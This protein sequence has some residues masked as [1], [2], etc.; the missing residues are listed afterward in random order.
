M[1]LKKM[2][3]VQN[4]D[5]L[6]P[7]S[8]HCRS[9][10]ALSSI[11]GFPINCWS[12]TAVRMIEGSLQ[13]ESWSHKDSIVHWDVSNQITRDTLSNK[14]GHV[15]RPWHDYVPNTL[16]LKGE[17]DPVP[18]HR[19]SDRQDLPSSWA[20][21]MRSEIDGSSHHNNYDGGI[22]NWSVP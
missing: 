12:H 18:R 6:K 2:A 3:V 7:P 19:F 16:T 22:G 17:V 21:Q 1:W 11:F 4:T 15:T 14:R 5:C 9:N 8:S 10:E 20:W 13:C